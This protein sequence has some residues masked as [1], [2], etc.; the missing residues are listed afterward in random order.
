MFAQLSN[1]SD[2]GRAVRVARK[3]AGLSQRALA[4]RCGCSQR[5]ISELERGKQTA[6]LGKALAVMS[7]LGLALGVE[8]ADPAAHGREA[9]DRLVAQMDRH[10]TSQRRA[11][12]SLSDYLE[13]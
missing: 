4:G 13:A 2:F 12:P 1:A 8:R 9:V 5:F 3:E 6:E 11:R 7:A 10:L